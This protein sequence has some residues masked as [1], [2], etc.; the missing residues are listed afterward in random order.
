MIGKRT[1]FTYFT[2]G[3]VGRL[4]LEDLLRHGNRSKSPYRCKLHDEAL[5]WYLGKDMGPERWLTCFSSNCLSLLS[6][7]AENEG[8]GGP[9]RFAKKLS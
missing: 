7:W 9:P 2:K 5:K 8:R 3:A 1:P 6:V 4:Q